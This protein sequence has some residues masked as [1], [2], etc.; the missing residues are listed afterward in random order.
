MQGIPFGITYIFYQSDPAGFL[1]SLHM[2]WTDQTLAWC[3]S[4]GPRTQHEEDEESDSVLA[5]S[6]HFPEDLNCHF[7]I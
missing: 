6:T 3:D 1:P 4:I 7:N 2:G 5:D